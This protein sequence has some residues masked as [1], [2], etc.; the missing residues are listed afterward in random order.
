MQQTV[1]VDCVPEITT[2]DSLIVDGPISKSRYFGTES[3]RIRDAVRFMSNTCRPPFGLWWATLAKRSDRALIADLAKKIT[4]LQGEAGAPP[5]NATTI[6]SRGGLHGHTVYV[7]DAAMADRLRQQ[8]KF[9]DT[10]IAPVTNAER[11]IGYLSKE[12]GHR[13]DGGGDRCRLS[14][15]L[16]RDALDAGAIAPHRHRNAKRSAAPRAP[17]RTR[18]AGAGTGIGGI[19]AV[20]IATMIGTA[21]A[22]QVAARSTAH[23]CATPTLH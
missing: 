9:G 10:T 1:G 3:D 2:A 8:K 20:L 12:V 5:Y 6:E 15:A 14:R 16:E 23:R 18:S 13:L 7:G 4:A 22:Q 19:D 11:L 17:R 21:P